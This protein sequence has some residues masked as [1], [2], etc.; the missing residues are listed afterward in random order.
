MSV[1]LRCCVE[2][3]TDTDLVEIGKC[4]KDT[5]SHL[6]H[7]KQ[8]S[9]QQLSESELL[10]IRLGI[11]DECDDHK[12]CSLHRNI[13]GIH[14][15]LPISCQ[16]PLHATRSKSKSAVDRTFSKSHV[17]EVYKGWGKLVLLGSGNY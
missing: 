6:R 5:W 7:I 1:D 14:C 11:F 15:K 9:N 16:H 2:N 4:Q 3:C 12:I 10:K 13:F 8:A 17:L